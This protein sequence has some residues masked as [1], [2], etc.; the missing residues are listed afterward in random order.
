M[1]WYS[2]PKS[3][4]CLT[5]CRLP[6]YIVNLLLCH[7]I[8]KCFGTVSLLKITAQLSEVQEIEHQARYTTTTYREASLSDS[9]T[10]LIPELEVS[11]IC[12]D[13]TNACERL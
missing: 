11:P 2:K 12:V 8:D 1:H 3:A 7:G 6:L 5:V 10:L 13:R 9:G 4:V